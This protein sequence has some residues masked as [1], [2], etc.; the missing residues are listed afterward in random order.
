MGIKYFYFVQTPAEP[1]GGW[2]DVPR[3]DLLK[4]SKC[5]N[6]E[7]LALA[8]QMFT[9]MDCVELLIAT[10]Q[11]AFRFEKYGLPDEASNTGSVVESS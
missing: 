6:G 5:W 7:K 1:F 2:A 4:F 8:E 9:S 10:T 3:E 11:G